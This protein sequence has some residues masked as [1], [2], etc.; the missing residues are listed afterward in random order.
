MKGPW[1][2]E[3]KEKKEKGERKKDR[4]EGRKY[5]EK[6]AKINPKDRTEKGGGGS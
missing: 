6:K 5:P 1:V 2:Q 4:R 3:E